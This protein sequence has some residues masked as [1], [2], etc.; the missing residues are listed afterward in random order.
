VSLLIGGYWLIARYRGGQQSSAPQT[1]A[2]ETVVSPDPGN[3][4]VNVTEPPDEDDTKRAAHH[5]PAGHHWDGKKCVP[6]KERRHK[7]K[8]K[9]VHHGPHPVGGGQKGRGGH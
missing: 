8:P 4:T 2:P 5:C 9:P 6:V 3:I 7:P 1:S